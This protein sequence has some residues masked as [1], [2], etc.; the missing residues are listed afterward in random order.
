M[1]LALVDEKLELK[2]HPYAKSV[3]AY[4]WEELE[5]RALLSDVEEFE[6]GYLD[7]FSGEWLDEW[8]GLTSNPVTVRLNIK[9]RGKY[10]PELVVR[11]SSDASP[12]P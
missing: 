3:E 12:S 7:T 9:A 1:Q 6:V 8:P 11:L 4:S 5:A 10:W 2:W